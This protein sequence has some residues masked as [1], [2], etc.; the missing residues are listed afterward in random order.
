MRDDK[1]KAAGKKENRVGRLKKSPTHS[2]RVP[3]RE[4]LQVYRSEEE[5]NSKGMDKE[6][7]T[8]I[9]EIREDTAR[10]S[11]NNKELRKELV[12][13]REEEGEPRKELAAVREEMKGREEK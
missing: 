3:E 11:E 2:E 8:M 5:N 1:Q 9:R 4:E 10:I 7:K 6:M 13:V 12:A